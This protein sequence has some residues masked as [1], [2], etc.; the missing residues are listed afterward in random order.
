[1]AALVPARRRG[2][3]LYLA[4]GRGLSSRVD[5]V[6][7]GERLA[8]AWAPRS[9]ETLVVFG[10][11]PLYQLRAL[12]RKQPELAASLWVVEA[13]DELRTSAEALLGEAAAIVGEE[14][15]PP[16]PPGRIVGPEGLEPLLSFLGK[17]GPQTQRVRLLSN[18]GLESILPENHG[19]YDAARQ[20]LT[21]YLADREKNRLT[22]RY[23][24]ERWL[25]NARA[26]AKRPQTAL[27]SD[28]AKRTG[29]A[30]L[31]SSGP[32]T[33]REVSA[34]VEASRRHFTLALPGCAAFLAESGVRIGAFLSTDGGFWNALHFDAVYRHFPGTTLYCPFSIY[35]SIPRG[36]VK[37]VFFF[38][39]EAWGREWADSPGRAREVA[40]NWIPQAGTAATTALSVLRRLGFDS[41]LTAGID[42]S[43]TPWRNHA[44]SNITEELHFSRC[45]RKVP[46]DNL[47]H[48]AFALALTRAGDTWSDGKLALY[49]RLFDQQA[50][51]EGISVVRLAGES[52]GSNV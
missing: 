9:G 7:E 49:A 34:L 16:L 39:D 14:P 6:A 38:D 25:R 4:D 15:I 1:M 45:G 19:A 42:F 31:I 32:S 52:R 27:L 22:D 43:L 46:F 41:V 8:E 17:G 35:P 50:E 11:A 44:P 48:R 5:P 18:P 21:N 37:P 36:P 24:S 51:I 29:R 47:Y 20:K 28:Q 2:A 30:L 23:F 33:E 13:M 26:N 40:E 10:L 3:T 12:L